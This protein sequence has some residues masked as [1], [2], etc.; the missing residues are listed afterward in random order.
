M[1]SSANPMLIQRN[2]NKRGSNAI[3]LLW[4]IFLISYSAAALAQENVST[5]TVHQ[6]S[7]QSLSDFA[8]QG[9]MAV[10]YQGRGYNCQIHWHK[11][12]LSQQ[13][14]LISPLGNTLADISANEDGVI[15]MTNDNK[16][17]QAADAEQL[18]EQIIG[19]PLPIHLLHDWLLGRP[20]QA[21]MSDAQWDE[22]GKLVSFQQSDWRVEYGDYRQ[23]E[24]FDLP[25]KLTLR[26]PK[27][28]L[29]LIIDDWQ[30][31]L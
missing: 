15:L 22:S 4:L 3:S 5:T 2:L 26:H 30:L 8:I 7:L 25:V 18:T 10:Q 29:R 12:G 13:L 9:R 23:V 21:A 17:Y 6:A 27:I 20:A 1:L 28:Y 14:S 11:N 24:S 19:W 16:Q 31:M